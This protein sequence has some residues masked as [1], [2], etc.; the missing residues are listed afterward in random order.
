[1]TLNERLHRIYTD[2][3]HEAGFGGYN[4][5]TKA[6]GKSGSDV[7]NWLLDQESYSLHF[8]ARRRFQRN[9][10]VATSIGDLCQADLVD[11][12]SFAPQNDGYRFLLT[13]IDVFSKQAYAIPLK[14][15]AAPEI[16]RAFRKIFDLFIPRQL[17]TDRGLEFKNK[18]VTDFMKSHNVNM[19][20]S[21]NQ[22]VKAAVA[23]RFNRTLKSKM[24]RYFTHSGSRRYLEVLDNLLQ[25][26]NHSYHRSIRMRPVDVKN[27]DPR[28]IFKNLYGYATQRDMLLANSLEKPKFSV[29]DT[30]RLRYHVEPFSKGYY[31]N[32]SDQTF[33]VS[34]VV[35]AVPRLMYKVT[36][37]E[38][39]IFPRKLYA[40][41]MLKVSN[42]PRY[43]IEKIIKRR[44][45]R[46]GD[47]VYVKFLNYPESANQW[48]PAS[49]VEDVV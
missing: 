6:I 46:N 14:S 2:P 39:K 32:F 17:Q 9:R 31:P 36:D 38:G 24:F 20:F 40:E 49:A 8:P 28:Q 18:T 42:N 13:F 37:F 22:D 44:K 47:Q 21:F 41:D 48:L 5:L 12:S 29:G 4:K 33:T 15:K 19:Y 25:S 45:T 7:K 27:A 16:V 23:E 11:M 1:M 34:T 10:I 35:N 26:Y 43:R 30:V 3:S